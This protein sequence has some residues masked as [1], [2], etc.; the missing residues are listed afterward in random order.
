MNHRST[1]AAFMLALTAAGIAAPA[2]AQSQAQAPTY[3]VLDPRGSFPAVERVPLATRLP[4]LAGKRIYIVMSWPSGSGMDQVAKDIAASL[5]TRHKVGKAVIR[6]RN[7]VYSEDDPGLWKEMQQGG[8][9]P[10]HWR[11]LFVDHVVCIQVEHAP[12]ADRLARRCGL[13]RT[14]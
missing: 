6:N 13:F 14:A 3:A 12:R 8:W 7:T 9:L 4:S 10:I 11:R 1:W 2:Q 5:E